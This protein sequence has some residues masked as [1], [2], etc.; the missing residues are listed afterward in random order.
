MPPYAS[1]SGLFLTHSVFTTCVPDFYGFGSV[2]DW[3]QLPGSIL[4][5]QRFLNIH[6][7]PYA[8]QR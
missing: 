6:S 2:P 7:I 8:V 5:D 3:G 1:L 4:P